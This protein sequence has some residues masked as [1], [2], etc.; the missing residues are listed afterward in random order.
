VQDAVEGQE[1]MRGYLLQFREQNGAVTSE[2]LYFRE[3]DAGLVDPNG[4]TRSPSESFSMNGRL[5]RMVDV[6][7]TEDHIRIICIAEPASA[8]EVAP[9]VSA[10]RFAS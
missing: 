7:V 5:W 1:L 6:H 2:V 3:N 10:R 8:D 4:R 9:Y